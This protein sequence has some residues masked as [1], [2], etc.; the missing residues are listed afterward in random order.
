[1]GL[2]RAGHNGAHAHQSAIPWPSRIHWKEK[3]H[4]HTI[5]HSSGSYRVIRHLLMS[6]TTSP[7]RPT[8]LLHPGIS[9]SSS[10]HAIPLFWRCVCTFPAHSWKLLHSQCPHLDG[11]LWATFLGVHSEGQ[12]K[13]ST[14]RP[15]HTGSWCVFSEWS[16]PL[17]FFIFYFLF[18]WLCQVLV[19]AHGIFSCGMWNLVPWLGIRP[20]AP[21][22]GTWIP[23]HWTTRKVPPLILE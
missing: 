20:R 1:M 21:A 3:V 4:P 5:Q 12:A 18:T 8:W 23:I 6:V 2:Q 16:H 10:H 9:V 17:S 13:H 7:R 15:Y 19:V 11:R 22:L 14:Q